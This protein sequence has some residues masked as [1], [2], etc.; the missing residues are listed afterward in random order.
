MTVDIAI[1]FAVLGG[2]AFLFFTE[3]L[4]VDLTA[5]M[6][7]MIMIL[8]GFVA[9]NQAFTGFAS[10]AVITML[11]IFFVSAAML[12]TGVA[13]IVGSWVYRTVGARE[14]PLIVTIMTV[15]GVLSAFMNNIAAVAVLLPAVASISR[16]SGVP[17]SRLFMPLSFGAILGGT[18]TLVGTPPNILAADML[19][20]RGL[21]PFELFD[22]TAL[23]LVLLGIGVLFMVT[24][25]RKLLPDRNI[26]DEVAQN[27]TDLTRAYHL[28]EN[29]LS[30]SVP[31]GSRL[32]GATLR[33]TKLGSA[34]GVQVVGII[35]EG[36][37]QLAPEGD[38]VL[39]GNDVLLVKGRF[40]DLQELF[41]VQG[42]EIGE[43]DSWEL[44]KPV[45]K[46]EGVSVTIAE[47]SDF[48]GK[49]LRD[50]GFRNRFG[51]TVVGMQRDGQFVEENMASVPLRPG[52][53]I[54]SIGRP[55]EASRIAGLSS[56]SEIV[57]GWSSF[58][59]LRERLFFLS[60]PAGSTLAG[61]TIGESRIGE[62]VDLTVAAIIREKETVLGVR[63]EHRILEGDQLL[64]SGESDKIR[65]LHDLGQV[66]IQKGVSE[67]EI[68]SDDV[69]VV[70]ATVAP[71]SDAAGQSLA[72]LNFREKFGLQVLAIWREGNPIHE[73][74]ATVPL[75]FGDALLIQGRWQKLQ[76]FG[77]N[78][79]FV[80]L[81]ELV[82]EP[83]RTE[84]A[85]YAVGALVLMIGFVITGF[86]PIHVAA[87]AAAIAVVLTGAI[88][89]EEAY[90]A[91]EWR[92]I[93]L[94]AAILPVGIAMESTGAAQLLSD[95]VTAVAG[96]YGSY[97]VLAGLFTLSSALSQCLDGA[98]AV[99]LLTP[100]ALQTASQLGISPYPVMMGIS[101]AA[102]AAFM[103]PFSHKANLIVMG[104]GGYKVVDYLKV[105]TIL[106]IV[107]LIV[108]VV[109]VPVFFPL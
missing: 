109:L 22:F 43:G 3:K 24:I 72:Q 11:S 20:E 21:V 44:T 8:A 97:A 16:K 38:S 99:V 41:R 87:F 107:L 15:A 19:R 88:T 42:V 95:T 26:A 50:L 56:F 78:R 93:F 77:T 47:E 29:L 46:V 48:A 27:K 54:L 98:P 79:D 4:P 61:T 49:S 96:P 103:T 92:A 35:R 74:L 63:P 52:D 34:L 73:N 33:E 75:R 65:R 28:Q 81:S 100:V 80:V 94:V 83:R 13:D 68:E 23:G 89:M 67:S 14:I 53:R 58:E 6:G 69:G 108:M 55:E 71:R 66:E 12:H 25:G 62:L 85:V 30:I 37:K 84:K 59:E 36:K 76:L 91:V 32:D 57:Y 90:R 45:E 82:R 105:G 17:P 1:L 86:Q 10:P 51:L 60:V 2:M 40:A 31:P 7:L 102:S 106:T 70:E 104:A 18:T 9:P 101:L 5:F 64:V 39:R